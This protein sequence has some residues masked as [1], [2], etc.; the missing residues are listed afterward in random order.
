MIGP[1]CRRRATRPRSRWRRTWRPTPRSPRPRSRAKA[2]DY[3]NAVFTH[4]NQLQNLQVTTTFTDVGSHG[5]RHRDRHLQYQHH[6]DPGHQAGA[7]QRSR[8]PRTSA[9]RGCASRWCS[10]TPDR[11]RHPARWRRSRPRPR[12]PRPARPVEKGGVHQRRRL[13][14]DHSVRARTSISTRSTTVRPGSTGTM[15]PIPTTRPGMPTTE[16]AAT[17]TSATGTPV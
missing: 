9:P 3:F 2:S 8:R 11:W 4:T 7:A 14:V 13:R 12:P 5:G 6:G 15:R 16:P 17:T 1:P 10:T